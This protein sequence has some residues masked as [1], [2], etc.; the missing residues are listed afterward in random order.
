MK[1]FCR[2]SRNVMTCVNGRRYDSILQSVWSPINQGGT[3][4][5][6]FVLDNT[7]I[8]II[9]DFFISLFSFCKVNEKQNNKEMTL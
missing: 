7:L 1:G 3:A 9:R 2:V 8:R 5:C 4:E 6:N